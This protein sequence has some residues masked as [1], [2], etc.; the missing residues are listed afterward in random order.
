[1]KWRDH[2]ARK[3]WG[4]AGFLS[5]AGVCIWLDVWHSTEPRFVWVAAVCALGAAHKVWE[6][7]SDRY[8]DSLH[9]QREFV[10]TIEDD[11]VRV[12]HPERPDQTLRFS[13]V[14]SMRV[15]T[16]DS[17]PWGHDFWIVQT[18]GASELDFPS[19]ATGDKEIVDRGLALERFD[20]GSWGEAIRSR[21][22]A[23]FVC[24]KAAALERRLPLQVFC[25]APGHR[26][27][28]VHSDS[29]PAWPSPLRP[30]S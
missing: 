19:G 1:M 2:T 21:R 9:P 23:T 27:I 11:V 22:N 26:W 15:E 7:F 3:L 18:S 29:I 6:G 5:I 14:E 8:E 24:W 13:D 4:A 16:N 30:I 25:L 10:I 28:G 20:L 12:Q 17:G